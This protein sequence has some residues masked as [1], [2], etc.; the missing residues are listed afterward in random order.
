MSESQL[1]KHRGKLFQL[2]S[3][4]AVNVEERFKNKFGYPPEIIVITGGGIFAGP[5]QE[6]GHDSERDDRPARA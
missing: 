5:I 1:A 6:N 3:L 4:S 2:Y